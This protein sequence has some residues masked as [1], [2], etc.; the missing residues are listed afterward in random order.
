MSI[1]TD[2]ANPTPMDQLFMA[3]RLALTGIPVRIVTA[4][5]DFC[6]CDIECLY[7]EIAVV[8]PGG[9]TRE[10]DTTS[11]LFTKLGP[12]DT[13]V[14]KIFK[15]EALKATIVDNT[16]GEFFG[17]GFTIADNPD[18]A[19]Y[20]GFI[21]DW[22]LVFTAF[23]AGVYTVRA[24]TVIVGD[25]KTVRSHNYRVV[26]Y[27]DGVAD[28]TIRIKTIQNGNILSNPLNYTGLQWEQ[29]IRIEGILFDKEP[30]LNVD[31]YIDGDRRLQQIQDQIINN[32][33][34][35]TRLLPADVSSKIIY[36][37]FLSNRILVTDYNILN[38]DVINFEKTYNEIELYPE[39]I[40]KPTHFS[41][42]TTRLY[43]WKFV[44]KLQ[45]TLKRNF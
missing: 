31:N 18:A 23:G 15:G 7:E 5:V 30:K 28:G 4:P 27:S 14:F 13:I 43:V 41:K 38:E 37:L 29:N 45:N 36:D 22:S 9:I 1:Q 26:Q 20:V 12:T 40:E 25:A 32:F 6:Y 10:N 2:I 42:I 21:V 39:E 16:F 33:T 34:I 44:D 17:A 35:E 19:D 3:S 11:F 24:D 8:N